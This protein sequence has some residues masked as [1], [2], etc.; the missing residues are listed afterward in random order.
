MRSTIIIASLLF[1]FSCSEFNKRK[2]NETWAT[3]KPG[4]VLVVCTDDL[5]MSAE[6]DS[7]LL[8]IA[9]P[10]PPFF[11]LEYAFQFSHRNVIGFTSNFKSTRNIM[12][13]EIHDS[14][15]TPYDIHFKQNKWVKGQTVVQVFVQNRQALNLVKDDISVQIQ[16]SFENGEINRNVTHYQSKSNTLVK[17]IIQQKYGCSIDF[18]KGVS[19][20]NNVENFLRIDVPDR[21][22]EMPL[23]GGKNYQ[24]S[25]ANFILSSTL[26]WTQ[27][28]E[29]EEQFELLSLLKHQDSML[30][31][32]AP[33]EK[34]GAHLTTEY[35]TVVYPMIQ[36]MNISGVEVYEIKGHYRVGG[37][38]DV[39]M[40]GP[41]VSY[42]F[43][44]PKRNQIVTLFGMVHGPSERLL[45]YIREHKS[46]IHTLKL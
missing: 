5:W 4:Q 23:D 11:P 24:T 39:F 44:N 37:R 15:N 14:L 29:N 18:P 36:K 6:M 45:T 32:F 1:L 30:K 34:E 35:D 25:K 13:V 46:L 17:D 43:H 41:F 9:P 12:F 31:Q 3:G 16:Q 2:N 10:E 28:F 33:H 22:R 40:G 21:S 19:V 26:F 27:D 8:R 7:V 20:L 42:S 38:S